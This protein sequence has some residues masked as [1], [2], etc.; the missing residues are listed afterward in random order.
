MITH[1][2]APS[3]SNFSTFVGGDWL[4]HNLLVQ[5]AVHGVHHGWGGGVLIVKVTNRFIFTHHLSY[6]HGDLELI[7]LNFE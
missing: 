1:L 4:T 7:I 2:L 5:G 6:R 3:V